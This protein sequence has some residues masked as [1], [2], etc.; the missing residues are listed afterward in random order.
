[1]RDMTPNG[2]VIPTEDRPS[3]KS[4][5]KVINREFSFKDN[6]PNQYEFTGDYNFA[7]ELTKI[8]KSSYK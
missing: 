4:S 7:A 2:T 6:D 5:R 3:K 8:M 1:M